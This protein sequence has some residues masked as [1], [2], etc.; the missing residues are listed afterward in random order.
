M[1]DANENQIKRFKD[2][3]CKSENKR[4]NMINDFSVE[5]LSFEELLPG[6]EIKSFASGSKQITTSFIMF[7]AIN[8]IDGLVYYPVFS[9]SV[10]R[11]LAKDW[12][13]EIP[14]KMS[15]LANV[16][17]G[18]G[19]EYNPGGKFRHRKDDNKNMLQLIR[20]ARSMMILHIDEPKPMSNPFKSIYDK[21]M[22]N[23]GYHVFESD[24]KSINTAIK[25][26]LESS[27]NKKNENF[28]SLQQYID[29]LNSDYLK[30]A[31]SDRRVKKFNFDELRNK[32]NAKYPNET[33]LF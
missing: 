7:K 11:K 26:F 1:Q 31:K 13:M 5:V 16:G 14:S 17:N 10:G 24:I 12:K 21:L 23:P 20:L 22:S 18:G 3:Y 9:E 2:E 32:M 28:T 15:V 27:I 25:H 4:L 33:I 30:K 19:G 8:K 6:K 29:Y